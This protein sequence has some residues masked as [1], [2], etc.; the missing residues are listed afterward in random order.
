[1]VK[2]AICNLFSAHNVIYQNQ[3]FKRKHIIILKTKG[4]QSWTKIKIKMPYKTNINI[5]WK[6][7][8]L[9]KKIKNAHHPKLFPSVETVDFQASVSIKFADRMTKGVFTRRSFVFTRSQKK[10]FF[11]Q[12]NIFGAVETCILQKIV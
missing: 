5:T 12:K 4:Y 7:Q 3:T 11:Q 2:I 9:N 8:S 10:I 6:I 1:L